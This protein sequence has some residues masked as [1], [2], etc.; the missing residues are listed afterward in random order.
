MLRMLSIRA[1]NLQK[2]LRYED[3][4]GR[5]GIYLPKKSVIYIGANPLSAL[6]VNN[7]I[8]KNN[9]FTNREIESCFT[10]VEA[11]C[12]PRVISPTLLAI[13]SYVRKQRCES[14]LRHK[15]LV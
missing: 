7:R 13:N 8:L 12:S 3:G 5:S 2:I 14:Y 1:R 6:D 4:S 9:A 10:M 15:M 11:A